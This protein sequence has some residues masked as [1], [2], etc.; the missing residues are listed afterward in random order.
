[1]SM[2][3]SPEWSMVGGFVDVDGVCVCRW[4][5]IVVSLR[6]RTHLGARSL[7]PR[8]PFDLLSC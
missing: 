5:A 2:D 1:M 3:R 6:S 4:R 8:V 7:I